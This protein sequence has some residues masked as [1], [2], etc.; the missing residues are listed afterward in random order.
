MRPGM[1]PTSAVFTWPIVSVLGASMSNRILGA[2]VAVKWPSTQSGITNSSMT[3]L[4]LKRVRLFGSRKM[5]RN[6]S[7][8]MYGLRKETQRFSNS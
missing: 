2:G 3:M 8:G 6:V 1:A 5:Q 4:R 7:G